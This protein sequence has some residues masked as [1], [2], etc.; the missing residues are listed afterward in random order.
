MVPC[1]VLIALKKLHIL[2]FVELINKISPELE[3]KIPHFF[4]LHSKN[5]AIF[6]LTIFRPAG[7]TEVNHT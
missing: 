5:Q 6:R 4:G 7:Y 3:P 1:H 2:P